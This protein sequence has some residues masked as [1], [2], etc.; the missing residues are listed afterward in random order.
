MTDNLSLIIYLHLSPRLVFIYFRCISGPSQKH[1]PSLAWSLLL[2]MPASDWLM[3]QHWTWMKTKSSEKNKCKKVYQG[4][5][6]YQIW[7][8]QVSL[9]SFHHLY[10]QH[11]SA[12]SVFHFKILQNYVSKIL[13]SFI[14]TKNIDFWLNFFLYYIY[15]IFYIIKFIITM[16]SIWL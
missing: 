10:I 3:G 13:D 11:Q 15:I 2:Q 5:P 12:S 8:T 9:Y 7:S 6:V 14:S 4:A 16:T 1:S